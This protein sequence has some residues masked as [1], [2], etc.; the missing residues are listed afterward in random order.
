M[1]FAERYIHDEDDVE[2]SSTLPLSSGDE[3][4]ADVSSSPSVDASF[5]CSSGKG[6]GNVPQPGKSLSGLS[7]HDLSRIRHWNSIA[8]PVVDRCVHSIF[9]E[10]ARRRPD[11][12]AVCAWDGDLT[13]RELDELSSR[14]AMHLIT[15]GVEPGMLVA[16]CF[17][18]SVWAVVAMLSVMKAGAA[19]V[20]LGP[21]HPLSRLES[22]IRI[23][24]AKFI[25]ASRA[26]ADLALRLIQSVVVME[27]DFV[28]SLVS[29][30]AVSE[31]LPSVSPNSVAYVLFTSG[32]TGEPKGIVIEHG[33]LSTSSEAHGSAWKIGFGTRVL[34]FAAYTFDVSVADVF[35]TLTRGG[36]VC[37][38][39]ER[40]RFE[41]LAGAIRRMKANWA[42]LTPSVA[43]LLRPASVPELQTLVLGGE[44]ATK[45]NLIDWADALNLIVCYGPAE[46]TVYC[47]GTKPVGS[48][49]DPANIGNP[50]GSR[51]WIVNPEDS[52]KLAP[53]GAIGELLIEGRIVARGYL[54]DE[55]KTA[56]QFLSEPAWLPQESLTGK[57]RLYKSGDLVRYNYDGTMTFVGRKDLQV[58]IRGQRVEL[59][60]IEHNIMQNCEA[61]SQV[62]VHAGS[63]P[64]EEQ[65]Q[66]LAAFLKSPAWDIGGEKEQQL[67]KRI[68]DSQIEQ[69]KDLQVLL[70]SS[71][72]SYMV[73]SL[74]VPIQSIPLTPSGKTDRR[75]LWQL[76]ESFTKEELN[77]CS[78]VTELKQLPSTEKEIKMQALWSAVLGIRKSSIGANDS[79]LRLGGDSIKAM[80]LVTEAGRAGLNLTFADILRHTRLSDMAEAATLALVEPEVV[81]KSFSMVK[82]LESLKSVQQT[83]AGLCNIHTESIEDIYP[84]T[85]LQE[86]LIVLSQKNPGDYASQHVIDLNGGVNVDRVT[87]AWNTVF[88]CYDIL[89]TRIVWAESLKPMQVVVKEGITWNVATSL[90]ECL[91]RSSRR[92]I[93]NGGLLTQFTFIQ[94][95][96]SVARSNLVWEIHHALYD[97]FS[98][99]LILKS[100]KTAYNGG[101]VEPQIPFK[102]FITHLDQKPEEISLNWWQ[103]MLHGCSTP[104]WPSAA[105]EDF[106]LG[107]IT[108]EFALPRHGPHGTSNH[109]IP[110]ILKAS[111]AVLLAAYSNSEDVVFGCTN[112]GRTAP[113]PDILKVAGPTMNTV[114]FRVVVDPNKTLENLL[115]LFQTLTIEMYPH[116][117]L[118]LQKIKR[119]DP[120]AGRA[121]SFGT[122]L[123][124]QPW[125]EELN[126][127]EDIPVI[128]STAGMDVGTYPITLEC[129]LGQDKIE[130]V[131]NYNR[132]ILS[133]SQAE[134]L[135][136]QFEVLVRQMMIGDASLLIKDLQLTP[137]SENECLVSQDSANMTANQDCI[138]S[139]IGRI[140]NARPRAPAVHAW[141][142][143]F[144]YSELDELSSRVKARLQALGLKTGMLVPICAEKSAWVVVAMLGI[145][146]AGGAFVPLDSS[147]PLSRLRV[148]VEQTQA[149][150]MFV[151]PAMHESW[152]SDVENVLEVS[153]SI[154]QWQL[155]G[156]STSRSPNSRDLAYIIFTSGSTGLPKGVM[157][158]HGNYLSGAVSRMAQIHRN[159]DS[160]VIQFSS[161]SFDTSI[162]DILTTLLA[163]GCVCVPSENDRKSNLACIMEDMKVNCAD[164]TPSVAAL[165]SPADVPSLRV[166]ILGGESMNTTLVKKW[167]E[168]VK[169]INTY[170]PTECSIV[171][172]IASEAGLGFDPANIGST[173]CGRAW[174]VSPWNRDRLTPLGAVGE[175]LLEGPLLARGYLHDQAKTNTAF[176]T[177]L[178][179]GS[180]DRRFYM[181]GDLVRMSESRSLTFVRRK[182][183][184]V[185]VRGQRVE[186]EE[187]ERH[188]L[189]L[190]DALDVAVEM[191]SSDESQQVLAAF[192][193]MNPQH[194]LEDLVLPMTNAIESIFQAVQRDLAGILPDYMIPSLYI[195]LKTLPTTISAK[196]DRKRLHS[197]VSHMSEQERLSYRLVATAQVKKPET[198]LQKLLQKLWSQLLKVPPASIGLESNFFR[199]GGDS[200]SAMQLAASARREDI[201]LTVAEIFRHPKLQDMAGLLTDTER[202]MQI[203]VDPN[204]FSLVRRP[205]TVAELLRKADMDVDESHVEDIYP[206]TPL[207]EGLMALSAQY[208]YAY[209]AQHIFKLPID[210]DISRVQVSWDVIVERNAILRTR[211]VHVEGQGSLQ[212]V[213]NGK[214]HWFTAPSLKNYLASCDE[215]KMSFG[216]ELSRFCLVEPEGE[217][218]SYLVWS[219][220]HS[221]FDGH[222]MEL[223]LQ[224]VYEEYLQPGSTMPTP[225]FSRVVAYIEDVSPAACQNFWHSQLDGAPS[226]ALLLDKPR[227]GDKRR[228][229]WITHT[230][231]LS[232]GKRALAFSGTMTPAMTVRA[233]W[234]LTLAQY[235]ASDDIVFGLT[236]TGRN[237]SVAGITEVAA[238]CM[239]TVPMRIVMDRKDTI[240]DYLY[241]LQAQAVDM[242]P[243]EH[244]GLQ[245]IKRMCPGLT[246]FDN[247]LIINTEQER[248]GYWNL[249]ESIYKKEA[250]FWLQKQS[251]YTDALVLECTITETSITLLASYDANL[252]SRHHVSRI[253]CTFAHILGQLQT[254]DQ[255]ALLGDVEICSLQDWKE[256]LGWNS[257]I[258][259]SRRVHIHDLIAKHALTQP[260]APAIHTQEGIMNYHDLEL[261]ST[262]LAVYLARLELRPKPKAVVPLCFDKSVYTIIC[263]LAVLKC[264]AAYIAL[265]PS[266]PAL[267]LQG[268]VSQIRANIILAS[269]K[270]AVSFKDM[271][272]TT[273]VVD[274]NL[275]DDLPQPTAF[276]GPSKSSSPDDVALVVF[277]SGSTGKPKPISISHRAG[278]TSAAGFGPRM[279]FSSSSRVLQN[280]AYAFGRP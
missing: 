154:R 76:L 249:M 8:P 265:D 245:N 40:E 142:G 87:E 200:I 266:H 12:P 232:I 146:K 276:T 212:V 109:T 10:Q 140:S 82:P 48:K 16:L 233:A 122:L 37:V 108:H 114:P 243:Y 194:A 175:L 201:V 158:E 130:L 110:T 44:A 42:F 90:E 203:S 153:D 131:A 133:P 141:D 163:G 219:A 74:Y 73:P 104:S 5:C 156:P 117:Y 70:A 191:I 45:R 11:A 208:P 168:H 61:G 60:E 14:I 80:Y 160:R 68:S 178:A 99:P 89:R 9:G 165:L 34:Q 100:F 52:G 47:M 269:A 127:E 97:G 33:S 199:V 277:T 120:H 205:E 53:I 88:H 18:K 65:R 24:K 66:V 224:Q 13:Y 188:L 112:S 206:C 216:D 105:K 56:A 236:L 20:S 125:K 148:I 167:A 258:P 35:T 223:I 218:P 186:L 84:C 39:S 81:V 234:G 170:G 4:P 261:C 30:R 169:L 147:S 193:V 177:G 162:E 25:L 71:L 242:I 113:V 91:S 279:D 69:M 7:D 101:V 272:V 183:T 115:G 230:V 195:P 111:W 259:Q 252:A 75:K 126:Q 190:C 22:I 119:I 1:D 267:R 248:S 135:L 151:S 96:G 176:V 189:N 15:I 54:G 185:K 50:V 215:L 106:Q 221:V 102:D 57:R 85:A 187:V 64:G 262:K 256:I 196:L 121:C 49:S 172:T 197:V 129:K 38:P 241:R 253:L 173:T 41:D 32:T 59:G 134:R 72:P 213:F 274:H 214:G 43:H 255:N 150:T 228:E 118:G 182:D 280:A 139:F 62:V 268:M 179:W 192:L 239:T 27:H 124:V 238:P 83:I 6:D 123:V 247:I 207:Q 95:R 98:L 222:S 209:I 116:E 137:A 23:S 204:P 217:F 107:S 26:R 275:L 143:M 155:T 159:Q 273:I 271:D 184:Q 93:E 94:S 246:N 46:C 132:V 136:C 29:A 31:D 210:V 198:P 235:C 264:G 149:N 63:F 51:L 77:R 171:S 17:D 21:G 86:G 202:S 240:N 220:H 164:L 211:I 225:T 260:N 257:V 180:A 254:K 67:V 227:K 263:M 250:E 229:E 152:A 157:V 58:K 166:L 174:V 3:S 79:F 92:P 251:Y 144:T 138:H 55:E 78:L 231:P 244:T 161:Y 226:T 237:V 103:T 28:K 270:Y 145:L 19:C 36:C 181:T 278:C 128:R 2:D